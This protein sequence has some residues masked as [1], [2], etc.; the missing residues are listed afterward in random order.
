MRMFYRFGPRIDALLTRPA[1]AGEKT[2]IEVGVEIDHIEAG[3]PGFIHAHLAVAVPAYDPATSAPLLAVHAIAFG[4]S[5]G[6]PTDP[7]KAL[8]S[9]SP[10][11][12]VDASGQAGGVTLALPVKNVPEGPA[13]ILTVLV[14]DGDPSPA[15]G[16]S[17]ATADPEPTATPAEPPSDP[18][19]APP[20]AQDDP[21]AP[22]PG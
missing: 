19:A 15:P 13:S 1:V 4:K 12:S 22:A 21:S 8:A 7:R 5:D 3:D 10:Q 2:V 18:P 9:S 6:I 20:T 16:T 11:A 14:F 17:P